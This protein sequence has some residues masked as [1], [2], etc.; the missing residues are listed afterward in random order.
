MLWLLFALLK[1]NDKNR[2]I[3]YKPHSKTWAQTVDCQWGVER[4]GY[5]WQTW[6]SVFCCLFCCWLIWCRKQVLCCE[7]GECRQG[8]Y[9]A[10]VTSRSLSYP[11]CPAWAE[12]GRTLLPA[13]TQMPVSVPPCRDRGRQGVEGREVEE[14]DSRGPVFFLCGCQKRKEKERGRWDLLDLLLIVLL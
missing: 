2:V 8:R 9:G 3:L 12:A 6:H 4:R 13:G 14:W 10:Q 11:S 5:P 7:P 1:L